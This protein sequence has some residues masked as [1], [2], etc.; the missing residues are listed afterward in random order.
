MSSLQKKQETI[1]KRAQE[2]FASGYHCSESVLLAFA[3]LKGIHSDLIPRIASGFGGGVSR[4]C[5]MCGAVS[6]AVM[7]INLVKGRNTPLESSDANYALVRTLQKRFTE[8]NGSTNC[9]ELLGCD[10][11]TEEGQRFFK[12]NHLR[13]QCG[14]FV[15]YAASLAVSLVEK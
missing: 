2:L 15:A 13:D 8:R 11:G 7:S 4:T 12:D 6:G 14:R 9:R 1:S 10:L 5:G 3:E